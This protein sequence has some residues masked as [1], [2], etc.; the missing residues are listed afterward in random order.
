MRLQLTAVFG[1]VHEG[2]IGIEANRTLAQEAAG[3]DVSREP[4]NLQA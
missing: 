4:L 1:K 2:Y 3:P